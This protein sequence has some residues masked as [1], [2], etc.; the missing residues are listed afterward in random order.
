MVYFSNQSLTWTERKTAMQ[1]QHSRAGTDTPAVTEMQVIPVAGRDSMLLNLAGAHGPFFTRNLVVLKDSAGRTGVGEVPGSEAIRQTLER[2]RPLVVGSRLGRF[3]MA[4]N[5]IRANL[6]GAHSTARQTT[7]HKVTSE[8]EAAILKQPHEINLRADN[9]LTAVE[10]AL[11]DL[12]GQFLGVPIAALLGSGQQR[13]SVRMLAYL[14]YVGDRTC[15]DLPYHSD[16]QAKEDWLRLRDEAALT[17]EAVVRLAEAAVARYGFGDFKLKGGVMR[18]EQEMATVAAIKRR[19]PKA[20]VTL[21]PN[22]AW[23]LEEAVAL[24]KGR[25]DVLAYAE[26]PCGP[27]H[28]FSGREIMAEFRR[29][30][31]MP[32]ATN[33]VATDWRQMGHSILL[34]AVD[35]PLA[36]P[37]FWTMQG[38]VRVAQL[39]DAWGLTWGS[40]SNNHF[41]VSLAMYTHC[42][43]AAP[44]SITAI[45]THWIWQEGR[46]RLTKEPPRIVGGAVEVPKRPGLGIDIDMNQVRKAHELYKTLGSGARDD[47]A[48]MQYIMPGWMYDPKKPSM[49]R[50]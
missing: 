43:A 45:D 47:A 17:P 8:A 1:A 7:V 40:H 12:L 24:C 3:N 18:G 21:D 14:F 25:T 4:L 38:A 35:I 11:L 46:E 39:C 32:T 33:M 50:P 13:E 23:S 41:D 48:A 2:V 31:T 26:D 29:A 37:H 30:T 36:D 22:G 15:T 28:G 6:I 10:A 19:F 34:Q 27:E 42:A 44:G 49:V 5:S 20:R 16:K 9:V